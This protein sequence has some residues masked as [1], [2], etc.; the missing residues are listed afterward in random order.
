MSSFSIQFYS[1]FIQTVKV[2]TFT[3]L[4]SNMIRYRIGFFEVQNSRVS[5]CDITV[6]CSFEDITFDHIN[7]R[8]IGYRF[9][10]VLISISIRLH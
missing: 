10:V 3:F 7:N 5:G 9:C 2:Y 1:L 8:I 6:W 4:N